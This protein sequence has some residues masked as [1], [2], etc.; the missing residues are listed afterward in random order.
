MR[1]NDSTPSLP[2]ESPRNGSLAT[3]LVDLAK[4]DPDLYRR[5]S[6]AAA[7]CVA[8]TGADS[9]LEELRRRL[10]AALAATDPATASVVVA[11]L[12]GELQC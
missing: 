6:R 11:R 8:L 5:R 9:V 3:D 12:L 7:T 4:A 2:P 10:D 1:V